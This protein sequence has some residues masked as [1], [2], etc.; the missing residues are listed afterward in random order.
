MP[1]LFEGPFFCLIGCASLLI[2]AR[3]LT[4]GEY[5][6][7]NF[8]VFGLACVLMVGTMG[9]AYAEADCSEPIPPTQ[10][11]GSKAT[12]K[13]ISEASHD[14]N[15]FMHQSDDYQACLVRYLNDEKAKAAKNK[16]PVD[17]SIT[18]EVQNKMNEN[19][20]LKLQIA[21]EFQKSFVTFCKLNP[22]A[23]PSCKKVL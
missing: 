11:D 8:R 6:V 7:V 15:V 13:Q 21:G 12:L 16:T 20:N 14:T 9:T 17:S 18:D 2:K 5:R 1:R 19:Q 10:V 4:N 3:A 22:T 23:D